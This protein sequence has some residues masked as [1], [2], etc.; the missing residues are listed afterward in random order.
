MVFRA[1]QRWF[2]LFFAIFFC[3]F[4]SASSS[5]RPTSVYGY[6]EH[7][8][9]VDK[10]LTLSAKLDT[11]ASSASLHARHIRRFEQ[12]GQQVIQFVVPA[13]KGNVTFTCP[14][15][16]DVEIKAR[17]GEIAGVRIKK[18][19]IKRPLVYMPIR[20]GNETRVIRVNLANRRRFAYPLLLG[21]EALVAFN[22]LV[23]SKQ[24]FTLKSASYSS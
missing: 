22:G 7:A 24:K 18:P 3:G 10:D 17:S 8:T 15:A 4:V 16:G 6:V 21:R 12:D 1:T 23:D 9:L 14:Y 2:V 19:Y 5:D 13:K 11:G 20:L